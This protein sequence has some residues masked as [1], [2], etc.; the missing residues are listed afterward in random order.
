MVAH[1]ADGDTTNLSGAPTSREEQLGPAGKSQGP[2]WR[3]FLRTQA[4]SVIAADFFT[5]DT[6]WLQRL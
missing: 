5:V 3:E 1:R 6:I 4:N 2:T